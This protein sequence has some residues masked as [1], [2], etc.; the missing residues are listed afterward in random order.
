MQDFFYL[1]TSP[2]TMSFV[3]II[4]TT[5]ATK[6]PLLIKSKA[7]KWLNPAALILQQYGLFEPF[8]IKKTPNSPLGAS[9]AE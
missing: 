7:C 3:P 6:L 9:V 5:S 1:S 4:V 2:K 8:D